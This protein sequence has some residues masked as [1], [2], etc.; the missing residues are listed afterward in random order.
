MSRM[1]HHHQP[2]HPSMFQKSQ[3]PLV[4]TL[5]KEIQLGSKELTYCKSTSQSL[6]SRKTERSIWLIPLMPKTRSLRKRPKPRCMVMFP[7][8]PH[9]RSSSPLEWTK[10][11]SKQNR[12]IRKS[13]PS[14]EDTMMSFLLVT[15]LELHRPIR[16]FGRRAPWNCKTSTVATTRAAA[17]SIQKRTQLRELPQ[18]LHQEE[19]GASQHSSRPQRANQSDWD[20]RRWLSKRTEGSWDL[21]KLNNLT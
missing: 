21:N 6:T 11:E 9:S 7:S 13:S 18:S 16:D 5:E 4:L 2:Q 3:E 8:W 12:R 1:L 15:N 14:W 10:W 20:N 17:G 19:T